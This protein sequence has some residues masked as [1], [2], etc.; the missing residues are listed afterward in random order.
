MK[1]S[2]NIKPKHRHKQALQNLVDNGGNMGKA[3]VDAGYKKNTAHTPQK[4]T[5]SKGF[6]A[7]LDDIGLDDNTIGLLLNKH[8]KSSDKRASLQAIKMVLQARGLL[9]HNITFEKAESED[10]QGL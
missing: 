5:A 6:V 7:L 2:Y 3:M 4:M 10:Y 9:K 8:A 1:K